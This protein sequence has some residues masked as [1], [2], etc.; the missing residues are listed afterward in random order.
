MFVKT[1]KNWK[2]KK[3]KKK[4]NRG[5]KSLGSPVFCSPQKPA[6]PNSN[7]TRNK[8]DEEPLSACT[9]ITSKQLFIYLLLFILLAN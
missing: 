4:K 2:K 7:S 5:L 1:I 9:T 8:V 3:E 6:F